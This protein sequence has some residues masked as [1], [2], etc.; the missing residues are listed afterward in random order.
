[1]QN[2]EAAQ[3]QK[4]YLS[5]ALDQ[6]LANPTAAHA[7]HHLA[8]YFQCC[9]SAL[10]AQ[11]VQVLHEHIDD[12]G[13]AVFMRATFCASLLHDA[14]YFKVAANALLQLQ[15][16]H[17]DR[18]I[19]FLGVAW[20]RM[21]ANCKGK[22]EFVA[23]MQTLACPELMNLMAKRLAAA[24]NTHFLARPINAV[25]KVALI[26]S[27]LGV[28]GHAP[29]RLFL[30]HAAVLM[31]EDVELR[32]FSCQEMQI[33]H[34][35]ELFGNGEFFNLT[36]GETE[37][38]ATLLPKPLNLHLSNPKLGVLRRY[39]DMLAPLSEFDPDL[40]FF[41]GMYSPLVEYLYQQRPV[42]ALAVHAIAPI[43]SCDTWLCAD[44]AQANASD[45]GSKITQG[46]ASHYSQRISL[47]AYAAMNRLEMGVDPDAL[48]LVCVGYRLPQEIHGEWAQRMCQ[49]LLDHRGVMLL[50]VGGEAQLPDALQS[51]DAAQLLLLPHQENVSGILD[52]C[53]IY[54]NPV[55][56]GGGFSVLEAMA[57]CMPVV[58]LA[59]SDGGNKLGEHAAQDLDGYFAQLE[60]LSQDASLRHQ[61]GHALR[62]KFYEEYDLG[63]AGPR[64]LEIFEQAR[65]NFTARQT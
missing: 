42:V 55:R 20:A 8:A 52:C 14:K 2:E 35:S 32:A 28:L 31:D 5:D 9:D 11:I 56:M 64:L 12:Q 13:V 62:A 43:V 38:W 49:F 24:S 40:I 34:M 23:T 25:K 1:M 44:M 50:L 17:F 46:K 3:L 39:A 60:T 61:M 48:V 59:G 7:W 19:A 16:L 22:Q 29:T 53:D 15:P 63:Q 41:I 58:A 26:G 27:H 47:P 57:S 37:Q 65:Q 54:V 18:A 6:V 36:D 10:Q 51:V 4:I 33:P 30:Q 45:W 21:L